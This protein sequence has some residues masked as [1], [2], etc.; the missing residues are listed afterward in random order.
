MLETER[1]LEFIRQKPFDNAKHVGRVI[2]RDGHAVG[3]AT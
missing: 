1:L 2:E 3:A